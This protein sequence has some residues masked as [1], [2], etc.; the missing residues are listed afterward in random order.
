MKDVDRVTQNTKKQV[1]SLNNDL[2]KETEVINS[3]LEQVEV[4][5]QISDDLNQETKKFEI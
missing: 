4:M 5:N 2:K 3:L 1:N